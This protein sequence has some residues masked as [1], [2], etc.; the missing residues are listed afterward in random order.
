MR[1]STVC[2]VYTTLVRVQSDTHNARAVQ[3][4]WCAV[5]LCCV[6]LCLC[7]AIT[8]RHF[9]RHTRNRAASNSKFEFESELI[10]NRIESNRSRAALSLPFFFSFLLLLVSHLLRGNCCSTAFYSYKCSAIICILLLQKHNNNYYYYRICIVTA[11]RGSPILY[12]QV[13][14]SN[15]STKLF[16]ICRS[17]TRR[18]EL[19]AIQLPSHLR[20]CYRPLSI[21]AASPSPLDLLVRFA[22]L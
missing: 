12:S 2:C 16:T 6:V 4:H 13:A 8:E 10:R 19:K 18:V 17:A 11:N 21:T 22:Q 7:G 15:K 1:L 20:M 9:N 14:S 3:C 5:V